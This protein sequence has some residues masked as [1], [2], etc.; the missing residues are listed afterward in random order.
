MRLLD[1]DLHRAELKARMPFRYGIATLSE[2]P[3]VFV[4]AACEVGG[5][6]QA[7]VAAD[8]L[9]PKWFTKDPGRDPL[10][11]IEDMMAA[12][13]QAQVHARAIGSA[14]TVF[15]FWRALWDRQEAGAE[16]GSVPRLLA[17][18]GTSLVERA[19]IDAF[20]RARGQPFAAALRSNAFGIDLGSLHPELAGT[21]PSHWLP[22][23]PPK[24]VLARHTVG[25]SDPLT[26]G[27]IPL[28]ERL[29]DGLPQSLEACI[30]AYGL[31]HFKLK[32]A[33]ADALPR[34][35]AIAAVLERE[36]PPDYAYSLDGN[37]AFRT[38]A[39]FKDVWDAVGRERGLAS[40]SRR[41]LFI[42]QPFHREVALG[43]AI[44]SL[45]REWPSRPPII[46]DE[47]DSGLAS[48]PRALA[49]GYAGTSH[50][51]CK[52]VFK[53]VAG[54]CLIARR[55]Q[56][57]PGSSLLMTGEDLANIGPVALLQDLAVQA[58]LG[59][60]S[61]ERNG[62]HYFAGLSFWPGALRARMLAN[63]P[64]LYHTG[65]QGWPTLT[66][67]EGRMSTDSVLKAPFGLGFELDPGTLARP[68][69]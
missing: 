16:A 10:D 8:H 49:L 57:A 48:L 54:A 69:P 59:V 26:E 15:A 6:T 34:L 18:F 52:G 23:T 62:H 12:I 22:Q 66:I 5:R 56:V 64:D 37:E 36:A 33:A 67:S 63:H 65:A 25:L 2:L 60:T 41:L 40:F 42:E 51:N 32:V 68:V 38:V 27:D 43:D 21:E 44:G 31:R 61:V 19:L 29:R 13:R 1:T 17:H 24:T 55:R 53:G 9:P 58:A 47:S 28:S 35:R 11:E 39:E 46:I 45:G 7:G 4:R 30:A 20:C 50:K 14:P 3:H